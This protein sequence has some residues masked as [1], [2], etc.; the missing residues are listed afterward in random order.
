[1]RPADQPIQRPP[2]ARLLVVGPAGRFVHTMRGRFPDFLQSGDL[3]VANDAAT[4]P[5]SL[6]GVHQRTGAAVEVRLAGRSTVATDRPCEFTA[7]VFGPGDH[8]T[9]TEDRA[10][11]PALRPGDRLRFG[12][13]GATIVALRDHP[14][15]IDL[16]FGGSSGSIWTGLARHG[17]P[18]QYSHLVESIVLSHVWSGIASRPAAFEPPSAGFV[19]DWQMLDA[20]AAR[21]VSFATL[22]H[23]AGISSTGDPLLDARLPLDEPYEIPDETARAIGETRARGG[24]IVALGTTVTRALEHAATTEG[25]E[26]SPGP[27][28]ATGRI[29]PETR[30]R[31]VDAIL[32][33]VHEPGDTHFELLRAFEQD[34]TLHR[35]EVELDRHGY[36]THEFG[37]FV[38]LFASRRARTA[39]D[40]TRIAIPPPVEDSGSPP[41]V[42]SIDGRL[43]LN[44][45]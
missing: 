26:P 25:G 10:A 8:R 33:G 32:T 42:P 17:R 1:M 3:V 21:R 44:S 38:L 15:L 13:L 40:S 39:D 37:D 24:R 34:A 4:I 12:S 5:A 2:H 36:R 28:L 30:L 45:T 16:R 31:V 6:S 29:G 11:P 19:L 23:A 22:T 43:R 41:D 18:I 20:L 27:G 14:R 35:M 9:P 7:V